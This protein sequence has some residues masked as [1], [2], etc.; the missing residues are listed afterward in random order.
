MK[1]TFTIL[2]ILTLSVMSFAQK[3]TKLK[4][5]ENIAWGNSGYRVVANFN[6]KIV[7]ELGNPSDPHLL[8]VSDGTISGTK[9]I[10]TITQFDYFSG[11]VNGDPEYFYFVKEISGENDELMKMNKSTGATESILKASTIKNPTFHDGL[12][13]YVASFGDFSKLDPV[14]KV[15]TKIKGS[16]VFNNL[17][18][19]QPIDNHL[20]LIHK[21]DNNKFVVTKSDG[22]NAG[23]T[24]S[25]DFGL[26][27]SA[28]NIFE[29]VSYNNG[30]IYFTIKGRSGGVWE[31]AVWV[32]DGEAGG[33]KKL[34]VIDIENG[35]TGYDFPSSFNGGKYY[36]TTVDPGSTTRQ[37]FSSDGST[38]GT[39]K[40]GVGEISAIENLFPYKNNMYAIGKNGNNNRALFKVDP[41]TDIP[42][43]V[44][45]FKDVSTE[46]YKPV[47]FNDS[48][49]FVGYN[50]EYQAELFKMDG[51]KE[52]LEV[53]DQ[54]N[55]AADA[56]VSQVMATE[57][58]IFF[59]KKIDGDETELWLYDPIKYVASILTAS[60]PLEI[61]PNPAIDIVTISDNLINGKLKIYD[62]SGKMRIENVVSQKQVNISSLLSGI[63]VINVT[64][65]G[66]SYAAKFVKL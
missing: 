2:F 55:K 57:K 19:I 7:F 4:T 11:Y 40:I 44:M 14:T 58:Y 21:N 62:L 10:S 35:G 18:T 8:Y 22:T 5:F 13:Y 31:K 50:S 6:N 42:V 49:F 27:E 15:N 33:T 60:L 36:F 29:N 30:K 43:M 59:S 24:T 20:I 47:V 64:H 1:Y 3:F 38:E 63:Y 34:S 37:L 9:L 12:I 54:G 32:T 51:T 65:N 52:S 48:I 61:Y 66:K 53:I 45:D 56:I 17:Y 39:S 46:L 28:S 16:L 41:A 25:F 26:D 23:T